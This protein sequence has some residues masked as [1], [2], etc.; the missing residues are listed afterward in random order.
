MY[1]TAGV[2]LFIVLVGL[3][4][5][6]T[7]KVTPVRLAGSFAVKL[8]IGA[9]FL[10]L[11]NSFSGKYGLHVPINFITSSIAGVLGLAGVA[12]LAIIQIWM[13]N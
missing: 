13:L 11:L 12:A 6:M 3:I 1:I 9:F 2:I 8:V 7:S 10:F 5:S 4:G